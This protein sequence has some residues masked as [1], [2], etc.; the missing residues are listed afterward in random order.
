MTGVDIIIFVVIVVSGIISWIRGFLREA[1]ALTA[2]LT[3]MSV[4]F[5][6]ANKFSLL[7][8]ESVGGKTAKT[9]VSA[10]V[11]FFGVLIIGWIAGALVKKLLSTMKMSNVDRAIGFVFGVIRG[12][13][14]VTVVVLLLNLTAIPQELWW[15]ESKLLPKFQELA[16]L[17][18]ERLPP[19]L[20]DHF[21]FSTS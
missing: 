9:I 14:I 3:A 11:L 12:S 1:I 16:V 5:L 7:L 21:K 15:E 18:H 13:V 4:T 6:Y 20:A 8:P 17:I 2:W 10:V 19:D